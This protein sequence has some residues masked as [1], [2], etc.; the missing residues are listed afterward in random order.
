MLAEERS[1]IKD[2]EYHVLSRY[3]KYVLMLKSLNGRQTARNLE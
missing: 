2:Q 1:R 3:D